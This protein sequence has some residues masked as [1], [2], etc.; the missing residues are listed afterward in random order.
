[1]ALLTIDLNV[2]PYPIKNN[3]ND[4]FNYT[5]KTITTGEPFFIF[6]KKLKTQTVEID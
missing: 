6:H 4:L 1:L 3:K 2:L 5:K